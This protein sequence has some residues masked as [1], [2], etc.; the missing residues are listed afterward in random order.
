M[1]NND[2][3]TERWKTFLKIF[4]NAYTVWISRTFRTHCT[5]K[6]ART[7]GSLLMGILKPKKKPWV[8]LFSYSF[9]FLFYMYATNWLR[10]N[11]Q[12]KMGAH[13]HLFHHRRKIL[14]YSRLH[15]T[16][17]AKHLFYDCKMR[18]KLKFINN[19]H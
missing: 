13:L 5:Q 10:G 6:N 16:Y 15:R 1:H 18:L 3:F 2:Y 12:T 8:I 19:R 7:H 9:S 4:S 14:N 17:L 11:L